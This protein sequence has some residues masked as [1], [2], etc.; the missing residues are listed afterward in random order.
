M[1]LAWDRTLQQV[2]YHMAGCTQMISCY[3]TVVKLSRSTLE[4]LNNLALLLPKYYIFGL[5]SEKT[6]Q[7]LPNVLVLE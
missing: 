7:L 4:N 6:G 5:D 3:H 2:A 1:T